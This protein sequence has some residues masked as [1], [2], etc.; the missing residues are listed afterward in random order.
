MSLQRLM[1]VLDHLNELHLQLLSIAEEKKD[2]IARNQVDQLSLLMTK[3][4]RL[5]K[6]VAEAD[7]E[8]VAA[9]HAFLQ[10]KGIRSQLNLTISE[11]ARLVF[12]PE[13][14]L[15]LQETQQRLSET[16]QKLKEKNAVIQSLLHQSLDFVEY[17][18]NLFTS[19]PEDDVVYQHPAQANSKLTRRMF[20]TRG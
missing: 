10:E 4:S 3:E 16:L 18:L 5:L 8:R 6:Q 17:S 9:A 20:D 13:E 11:I 2:I 12:Q 1:N 15:R 19:R 14:R 7:E